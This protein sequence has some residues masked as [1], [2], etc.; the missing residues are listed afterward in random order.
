MR[1]SSECSFCTWLVNVP[2]SKQI[3]TIPGTGEAKGEEWFL[4]LVSFNL[5]FTI[6]CFFC[7]S[8]S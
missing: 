5:V 1:D 7:S 4:H 8:C 3:Y 6:P 2:N